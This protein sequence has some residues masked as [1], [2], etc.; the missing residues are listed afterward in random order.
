MENLVKDFK[1][2]KT[3]QTLDSLINFIKE[4]PLETYLP[5]LSETISILLSDRQIPS[6]NKFSLSAAI[7]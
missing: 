5:K 3:Q 2:K 7:W 6:E 4:N 1:E